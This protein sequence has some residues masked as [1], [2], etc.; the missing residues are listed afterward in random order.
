MAAL[1][2]QGA[3]AR[4]R[5]WRSV[6]CSFRRVWLGPALAGGQHATMAIGE[7]LLPAL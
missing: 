6:A 4:Q 3:A 1:A 5:L 2:A 7:F